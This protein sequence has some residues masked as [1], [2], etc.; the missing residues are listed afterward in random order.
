MDTSTSVSPG[1]DTPGE[2]VFDVPLSPMRLSDPEDDDFEIP[3]S[4][5][6]SLPSDNDSSQNYFDK[7][8]VSREFFIL[9][10]SVSQKF[11]NSLVHYYSIL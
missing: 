10:L 7:K 6:I 3:L 1:T 4:D 8:Q 9:S 5:D 2:D 11:S